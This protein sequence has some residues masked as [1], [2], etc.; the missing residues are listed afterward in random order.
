M[1]HC[2]WL[3]ILLSMI[4]TDSREAYMARTQLCRLEITPAIDIMSFTILKD[5]TMFGANF[6][7]YQIICG[8]LCQ[9]KLKPC[10]CKV[11]WYIVAHTLFLGAGIHL[12]WQHLS[13]PNIVTKTSRNLSFTLD[14]G[15]S[16]RKKTIQLF[17]YIVYY[18][19]QQCII[20]LSNMQPTF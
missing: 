14:Q 6:E 7:K 11:T 19:I 13:W 2:S 18:Y 15:R 12:T 4:H 5:I 17:I 16:T 20:L 9:I 3:R 1:L 8:A 10:W